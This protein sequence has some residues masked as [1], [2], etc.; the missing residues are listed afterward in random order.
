MGTN[1]SDILEQQRQ[2]RQRINRLKTTIIMSIAI[3]MLVSFLAIIV[4]VVQV[5]KLNSKIYKL[6]LQLEN[7][8][9][10]SDSDD[11]DNTED[12]LSVESESENDYSNVVTGIDTP[13]N[14]ATGDDKRK[15]YLTFDCVLSE[16]TGAILDALKEAG[17]K[18]TFF[19]S[20]DDTELGTKMLKRIVDEGHTLGMH[21]YSNQYSLIY[22][23]V[24]AF[25][26]DYDK[27][28]KF[29]L[30]KTGVNSAYY[31][32]PGGSGNEVSNVNM[33]EFVKVL[34]KKGVKYFDWNVSAG[35]I[36]SEYTVDDIVNNVTKGAKKY[37][38]SIVLMKDDE[39]KVTTAQAIV[40]LVEALK[41]MNADI[42]PIDEK[43]Y[44]VQYIR[45]DSVE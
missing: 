6:E 41:G 17:V 4:L 9:C 36:S 14:M 34:K 43:T 19:V 32:F 35:D 8:S 21:S 25:E 45:S 38:T 15:V 16:N 30:D 10:V 26:K 40:P 5:V 37:K 33:V 42:L 39:S 28:S 22:D 7:V 12:I 24:E 1:D 3:W 31:R 18:A 27:L 44:V 11:F 13:E 20:G 23:S 29:L 2:R